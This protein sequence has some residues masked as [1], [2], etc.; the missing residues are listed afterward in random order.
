M[1]YKQK[2]YG[3]IFQEMLNTAFEEKLISHNEDFLDYIS[4]R[5]DISNFYVM[6]LSIHAEALAEVYNEITKVY[7][8][9]KVDFAKGMDLDDIGA[10]VNCSRPKPTHAYVELNFETNQEIEDTITENEGLLVF[11][12]NGLSYRTLEPLTFTTKNN[13]CTV[14]AIA[15]TPGVAGRVSEKQLT[16]VENK[17]YGLKVTNPKPSTGG[18]D[19]FNDEQYRELLKNWIKI[20]Q[21]GNLWA[22]VNYFSRLDGLHDYKL[23]PNWDGTGTIKIV[24]SPFDSYF[25]NKVYNELQSKICQVSED[26]FL[27]APNEKAIDVYINCNVDIDRLNP[28][29]NSEKDNIKSRIH[30]EINNYFASLKIG[31]DFIPHK[32]AVWLDNNI[33]ELKNI[34]FDYPKQPVEVL[35]DESCFVGDIEINME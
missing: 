27:T 6:L 9:S 20:N 12:K 13:T 22:Y 32:L 2:Y 17:S 10:I 15:T 28:F 33:S 29:D 31:E 18:T 8:S 19:G 16:K 25:L 4:N 14:S 24:I 7:K 3:E 11:S 34:Q 1:N 30:D 35:D 21:K 23:I 5:K 26:I